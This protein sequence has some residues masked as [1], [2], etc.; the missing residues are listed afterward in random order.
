MITYVQFALVDYLLAIST[1]DLWMSK[2][3]QNVF[4]VAMNFISND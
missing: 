2:G 4:G 3:T 1:F